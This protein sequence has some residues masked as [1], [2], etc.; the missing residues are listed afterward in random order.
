M[1]TTDLIIKKRNG[2]SLTKEEIEFLVHNFTQGN[3]PDYQMA[4]FCMAVYFRG[5]DMEET[6]NLTL[7]MVNS[8]ETIDLA[9]IKGTIVDK[10]STGGVADTTTLVLAPLVA[11]AGV[12]VA[13]MSGRGLGHTGGTID[14]LESIPGFHTILSKEAFI[15]QVNKIGVA[16][17]GQSGALVPADK[18]IYALRDV[19]GTVDSIPLIASS[20][21]SKKIAAGAQ[22]IVLDV[23]TGSGAFMKDTEEAFRLAE[24]MVGIGTRAGRETVA[25]ISDMNEPLGSAIGN[26]LEVQEAIEVLQGK[27]SGPLR[28]LSLGLGSY[29]ILAAG[30]AKDFAEAKGILNGLL[31]ERR[32]LAKM[33]E[34]IEAQHGNPEVL[35]N[36]TLLPQARGKL[37][38]KAWAEGYLAEIDAQAL[39]LAAMVLGAGRETKDAAIDLAVGLKVHGRRGDYFKLDQPLLTLYYN[40]EKRMAEAM[41]YVREAFTFSPSKVEKNPLIYGVVTKKGRESYNGLL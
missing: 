34:L 24:T 2:Y 29:M 32:A 20:I 9:A 19:T 27:V 30:K 21:M 12:P 35:E 5:M 3:I 17:V 25:I 16:V 26:A 4:A 6:T 37:I 31:E 14:K 33:K 1:R 22:A 36:L 39:G 7:A 28:E 40:E 11:A 13:K 23:K 41:K 18:K 10:H 8:G 38:V 15:E